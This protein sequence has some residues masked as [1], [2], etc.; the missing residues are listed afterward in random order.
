MAP[1]IQ[2]QSTVSGRLYQ[3]FMFHS[4]YEGHVMPFVEVIMMGKSGA[5]CK[6]VFQKPIEAVWTLAIYFV[7][8]A[9]YTL[10]P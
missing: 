10:C 9:K 5:L 3:H 6:E 4:T 8:N 1:S 7:Q 2:Y